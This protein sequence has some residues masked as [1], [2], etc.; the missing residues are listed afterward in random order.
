[1]IIKLRSNVY[2]SLEEL[3]KYLIRIKSKGKKIYEVPTEILNYVLE[4]LKNR[5]ITKVKLSIED[6]DIFVDKN[7][8]LS[9]K[10]SQLG[11]LEFILRERVEILQVTKNLDKFFKS[12]NFSDINDCYKT[13]YDKICNISSVKEEMWLSYY[14]V[15][16]SGFYYLACKELFDTD[17]EFKQF[18]DNLK[19][20]FQEWLKKYYPEY[21]KYFPNGLPYTAFMKFL[22]KATD[23][24]YY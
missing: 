5:G 17:Q 14:K 15:N 22:L 4:Y 1:M 24:K 13:L 19:K 18:Q 3:S 7:N 23:R 8:E 6:T 2:T 10:P 16:R 21:T 12:I 9:R 11:F 20:S